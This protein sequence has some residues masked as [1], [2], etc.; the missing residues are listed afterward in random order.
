[1]TVIQFS[2]RLYEYSYFGVN[3]IQLFLLETVV[4]VNR[5]VSVKIYFFFQKR[6]TVWQITTIKNNTQI[7]LS[8]FELKQ[9]KS[10]TILSNFFRSNIYL[11][12]QNG[13]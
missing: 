11:R 4:M 8:L 1:M 13:L 2:H 5:L 12:N 7:D 10:K 3:V 6:D 9:S